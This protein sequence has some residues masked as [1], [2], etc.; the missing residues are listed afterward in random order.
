MISLAIL[1]R[2]VHITQSFQVA[3]LESEHS[4]YDGSLD[5]GSAVSKHCQDA[6]LHSLMVVIAACCV[7]GES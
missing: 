4:D 2:A 7:M 6:A 5:S 1:L 3:E